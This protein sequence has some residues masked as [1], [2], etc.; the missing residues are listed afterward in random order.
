MIGLGLWGAV[1]INLSG[2]LVLI[3]R[4]IFGDFSIPL[5][6]HFF[7]WSL[8]I[9]LVGISYFEIFIHLKAKT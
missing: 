2:G 7:L 8:A 6:G 3:L 9:V 4:L 5:R 1:A